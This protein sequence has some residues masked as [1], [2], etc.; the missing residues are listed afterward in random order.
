MK[1][2]KKMNCLFY[3]FVDLFGCF[4][5]LF[6]RIGGM[7]LLG[8]SPTLSF[9]DNFLFLVFIFRLILLAVISACPTD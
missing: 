8:R 3:L 7:G 9:D 4:F 2:E 6:R 1:H 5:F